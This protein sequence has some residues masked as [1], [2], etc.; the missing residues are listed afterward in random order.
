MV[1]IKKIK[2]SIS[3]VFGNFTKISSMKELF[4]LKYKGGTTNDAAA[5][6]CPYVPLQ[7]ST[8]IV[9]DTTY[10]QS[11]I[12]TTLNKI[13]IYEDPNNKK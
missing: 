2:Q 13:K 5:F 4:F 10:K 8:T 1:K 11:Y 3:S 12:G 6:Y 7:R 9:D